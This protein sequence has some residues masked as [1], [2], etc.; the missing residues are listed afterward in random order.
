VPTIRDLARCCSEKAR[1]YR[2]YMLKAPAALPV[3]SAV[4]HSSARYVAGRVGSAAAT[5]MGQIGPS[6]AIAHSASKEYRCCAR[7]NRVPSALIA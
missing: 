2:G 5:V 7:Y 3:V 6:L 1:H 4:G